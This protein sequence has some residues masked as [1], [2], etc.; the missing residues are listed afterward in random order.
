MDNFIKTADAGKAFDD[1]FIFDCHGHFGPYFGFHIPDLSAGEFVTVLDRIGIN[2]VV[3]STMGNVVPYGNDVVAEAIS[4][5]PERFVG[6]AKV[7]ANYPE[8]VETEL[9]RC[10]DELGFRGIKIHPYWDQVP[11]D[12]PRYKPVWEFSSERKVPVLIHTWNSH[13]Y[14]DALLDFC[15]PSLFAK[16]AE[17]YP[18]AI[19][20]LGHSG[21]EYD[22]ILDAIEV[23]KAYPNIYLDTASSRLYPEVIEMIVDEVGAERVLYGSDVPFLS[24]A[25]QVGKIVYADIGESEKEM[26]LGLNATKLFGIEVKRL[27]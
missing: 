23:A 7:N 22:G 8:D 2:A 14:V 20:L 10:F 9:I 11:P 18:D 12:D 1:S 25:P 5:Y 24:P 4:A 3:I 27:K 16:I 19:L 6:Y 13:R 21:G 26:I 15:L 17:D